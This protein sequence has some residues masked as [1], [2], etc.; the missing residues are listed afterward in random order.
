MLNDPDYRFER[1]MQMLDT[2]FHC[3]PILLA[4]DAIIEPGNWG[5]ITRR[6]FLPHESNRITQV[7]LIFEF[8]RLA[9]RP[10]APS[11]LS[12]VFAI[13]TEEEA[14]IYH[15]SQAPTSIIYAIRPIDPDAPRHLTSWNLFGTRQDASFA[16]A[17]AAIRSYWL[18]IPA[19]DREIL[20]GGP[21][22]VL[23][24]LDP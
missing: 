5:R 15:Q 21:V 1:G 24:K 3:A 19:M 14:R 16:S 11:R 22:R 9:L 23:R 7:E 18:D 6:N 12:S 20:I 2:Y 4:P 8:A 17:E 13:P 10:N